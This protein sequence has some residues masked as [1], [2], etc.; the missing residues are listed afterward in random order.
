MIDGESH[1]DK[2]EWSRANNFAFT[3]FLH[4]RKIETAPVAR[5]LLRDGADKTSALGNSGFVGRTGHVVTGKDF[6]RGRQLFAPVQSGK[7]CNADQHAG[8][9]AG[10][11]RS[12]EPAGRNFTTIW[13]P[14]PSAYT[15]RGSSPGSRLFGPISFILL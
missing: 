11:E 10:Q 1:A 13:W 4:R 12:S 8:R 14:P 15:E 7:Q 3:H 6:R 2:F 5:L 9:N